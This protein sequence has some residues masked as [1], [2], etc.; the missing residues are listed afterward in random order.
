ME[1]KTEWEEVEECDHSY[2]RRC[3]TSHVT[4]YNAAQVYLLFTCYNIQYTIY[5]T[6]VTIYSI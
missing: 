4:V 3:H 2:N 5:T 1:Q 6:H